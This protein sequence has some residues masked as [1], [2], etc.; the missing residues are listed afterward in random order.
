MWTVAAV[1]HWPFCI[2]CS[3]F[4]PTAD[5]DSCCGMAL[6]VLICLVLIGSSVK[7]VYCRNFFVMVLLE[8]ATST[9]CVCLVV[10]Q[11]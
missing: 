9:E 8:I 5:V 6:A 10:Y 2:A 3:L 1:W 7:S 11:V 4:G